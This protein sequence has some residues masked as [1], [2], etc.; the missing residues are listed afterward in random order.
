MREEAL[1]YELRE[2][3]ARLIHA[4][5]CNAF[6]KD[7]HKD[8]KEMEIW[9]GMDNREMA[10]EI[11][12]QI[13]PLI[14]A[15]AYLPCCHVTGMHDP[16]H[17]REGKY[18]CADQKANA[19]ERLCRSLGINPKTRSEPHCGWC[20]NPKEHSGEGKHLFDEE[21]VEHDS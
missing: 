15:W 11:I 20:E 6:P 7:V 18:I 5:K 2:E 14:E 19:F 13:I 16:G 9:K 3:I 10:E 21:A 17:F 8:E 12:A 1:K 4:R